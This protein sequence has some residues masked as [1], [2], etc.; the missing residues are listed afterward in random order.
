MPTGSV[1]DDKQKLFASG[2]SFGT[3]AAGVN[4]QK[5]S[6]IYTGASGGDIIVNGVTFA[7]V[8][9]GTIFPIA[10]AG[11]TTPA[12]ITDMVWIDW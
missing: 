11:V 4:V 12:G 5:F 3:L 1:V 6:A 2:K 7:G 9:G 8:P 10:G